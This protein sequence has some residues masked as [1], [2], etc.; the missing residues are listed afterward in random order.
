MT[1]RM[2]RNGCA[3]PFVAV[4][5]LVDKAEGFHRETAARVRVPQFTGSA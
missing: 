5:P 3:I 2:S 4:G 1:G